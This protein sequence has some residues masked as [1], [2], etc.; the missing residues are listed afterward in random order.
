MDELTM[1]HDIVYNG[2]WYNAAALIW[3]LALSV[4]NIFFRKLSAVHNGQF[5]KPRNKWIVIYQT[6]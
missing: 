5:Q 2:T 1:R 4:E 3:L 6:F